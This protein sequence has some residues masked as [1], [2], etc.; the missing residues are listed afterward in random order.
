[1]RADLI[2]VKKALNEKPR[3]SKGKLVSTGVFL[4][5]DLKKMKEQKERAAQKLKG[6]KR[7]ANA[8]ELPVKVV[9][10]TTTGSAI[11]EEM[12]DCIVVRIPSHLG[13]L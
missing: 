7:K 1:M 3:K 9:Q 4:L 11:N 5:E 13:N 10:N 8:I 12:E 2:E 6:R